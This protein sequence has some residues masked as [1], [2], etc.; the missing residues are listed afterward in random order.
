MGNPIDR[1]CRVSTALSRPVCLRVGV[2]AQRGGERLLEAL[3][4]HQLLGNERTVSGLWATALAPPILSQ[5][6]LFCVNILRRKTA[7]YPW[8]DQI[9]DCA[10]IRIAQCGRA[11]N[12]KS[13]SDPPALL[14]RWSE[15]GTNVAGTS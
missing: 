14:C 15:F 11:G 7:L 13:C 5:V 10:E 9:M 1:R 2:G 12:G 4:Q 8:L 3:N 6:S